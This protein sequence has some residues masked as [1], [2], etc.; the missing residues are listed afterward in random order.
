[1]WALVLHTAGGCGANTR[2][3]GGWGGV[4]PPHT[5]PAY[6]ARVCG[7]R[8][9]WDLAC[10]R[11]AGP[12]GAHAGP[13][14]L[15]RW[16]RAPAPR[17]RRGGPRPARAAL[18]ERPAP[19]VSAAAALRRH[20]RTGR[21]EP[22]EGAEPRFVP[23]GGAE[24]G[25]QRGAS[26]PRPHAWASRGERGAWMPSRAAWPLLACRLARVCPCSCARLCAC[27]CALGIGFCRGQSRVRNSSLLASADAPRRG[28]RN[29]SG[30][31][32]A[33]AAPSRERRGERG[34]EALS[35]L[36]DSS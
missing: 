16:G 1:G 3:G 13:G 18:P 28:V 4:S 27:V 9:I 22:A 15:R 10:G 30:A 11:R 24:R 34:G 25:A 26:N 21:G 14:D 5:P 19:R 33:I 29:G 35:M 7:E 32:A 17:R 23:G 2:D 20:E 8:W 36:G 6:G 12:G 31:A